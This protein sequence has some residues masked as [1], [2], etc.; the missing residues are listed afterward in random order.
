MKY[1]DQLV[2]RIVGLMEADRY[3]VSEVCDAVGI[4]RKTFYEW[5]NGKPDFRR[6]VEDAAD[7]CNELLVKLARI[8]LRQRL[9]GYTVTE[10]KITFEPARGSSSE[11]VEKSH[12]VRHRQYPPDLRAIQWVLER[13]DRRHAEELKQVEKEEFNPGKLEIRVANAEAAE[14]LKAGWLRMGEAHEGRATREEDISIVYESP[15]GKDGKDRK[16]RKDGGQP[17]G[18]M[19]QPEREEERAK[20]KPEEKHETS[21][22]SKVVAKTGSFATFVPPGYR[23]RR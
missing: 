11:K 23:Y 14:S 19:E 3:T 1:S 15:D 5:R 16:D 9:E 7:R 6:A 12:V 20:E 17:A 8:S 13:E 22:L 21:K 18:N 10:E 2:E 4:D